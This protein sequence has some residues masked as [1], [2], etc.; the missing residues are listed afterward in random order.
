MTCYVNLL[1]YLLRIKKQFKTKY[2][3]TCYLSLI[4]RA[5]DKFWQNSF[6]IGYLLKLLDTPPKYLTPYHVL[7][8]TSKY[9]KTSSIDGKIALSISS[10]TSSF[11]L[12]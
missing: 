8:K 12:F 3:I 7:Y 2:L 5:K 6:V 10:S 11:T 4:D 9:K 1:C